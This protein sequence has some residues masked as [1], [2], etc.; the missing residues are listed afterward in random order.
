MKSGEIHSFS[1][2]KGRHIMKSR[3]KPMITAVTLLA[4]L[5]GNAFAEPSEN[6][7]VF[8]CFGQSN[9]TGGQ[10]VTPDQNID[11]KN[12][13]HPRIKVLPFSDCSQHN[14]TNNVWAPA[15]E[16]LH[17]NDNINAM[18]PAYAFA[19]ALIDSLPGE[20]TIGLIAC[21]QW[22]VGIDMYVKDGFFQTQYMPP[23]PGA[24]KNKGYKWMMDK[25]KVALQKG[26]MAGILMHQ[27]ETDAGNPGGWVDKV[28]GLIKDI[29]TELD[30]G[31]VPFLAGELHYQQNSNFNKNYIA[32]LPEKIEN[33][34]VVSAEGITEL[35][36]DAY[37]VHFTQAGHREL[38]KRYAAQMMKMLKTSIGVQRKS[39]PS[40]VV[41]AASIENVNDRIR[42]YT[43][44][45]RVISNGGSISFLRSA[46]KPD[47]IYIV[48]NSTAGTSAMIIGP[49]GR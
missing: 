19:R 26:E 18:G 13:Q 23:V 28:A 36:Q 37:N 31:N 49:F 2:Y 10:N 9:M 8:L 15:Y 29:R 22:G 35:H 38:G 32:K 45:G 33:C 6:F 11:G 42:L 3:W 17:C 27:G 48:A 4:F 39:R 25:C 7:K 5:A 21:G 44:N 47:N 14:R 40:R 12:N 30:I 20:D 43:V 41:S 16:P 24:G 1:K 46:M 34:A